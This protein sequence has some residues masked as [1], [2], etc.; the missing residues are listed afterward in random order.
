MFKSLIAA[1]ALI[2]A[3]AASTIASAT[4][5]KLPPTILGEWCHTESIGDIETYRR[6][7]IPQDIC[8]LIIK[9]TSLV[10]VNDRCQ[11]IT[12]RFASEEDR[13]NGTYTVQYRCVLGTGK[14][15]KTEATIGLF[16]KDPLGNDEL[17]LVWKTPE[18]GLHLTA[19]KKKGPMDSWTANT[20]ANISV[21]PGCY[22]GR[23]IDTCKTISL[24]GPIGFHDAE[25]FKEVI[26]KNKITN[27]LVALDSPG[28]STFN[29]L[30]IG[31][32]IRE[33]NFATVVPKDK[34]CISA[35]AN[36]WLAGTTRYVDDNVMIGFHGDAE[37]PGKNGVPI[38]GANAVASA[39]GNAV[40]GAY[41][42]WLGLSDKAIYALTEKGPDDM[43]WLTSKQQAI[44]L[45]IEFEF[46]S[47]A[48]DQGP[49]PIRVAPPNTRV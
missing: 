15:L 11:A 40:V 43:L 49:P 46:V 24:T 3:L 21:V 5:V 6:R 13:K 41:L 10:V 47:D 18:D 20:K 19:S 38:K 42:G 7:I 4:Q 12:T 25:R 34:V 22:G 1:I 28:G 23:D 17:A 37:I 27:A 45:G 8:A 31:R 29:G 44:D 48:K 39:P 30:A 36:V 33:K 35:C 32:L 14:V 16:G 9:P 26:E 2:G